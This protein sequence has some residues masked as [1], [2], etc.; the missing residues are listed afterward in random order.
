MYNFKTHDN[1]GDKIVLCVQ[2][3]IHIMYNNQ[4]G[5]RKFNS[6]KSIAKTIVTPFE[7]LVEL[8]FQKYI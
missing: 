2:V 7:I 4:Q 8:S 3:D 6:F 5:L 1:V